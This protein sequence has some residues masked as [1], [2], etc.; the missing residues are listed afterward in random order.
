MGFKI[1]IAIW[2]LIVLVGGLVD[3]WYVIWMS[4]LDRD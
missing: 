3:R 1:I 2:L 4:R